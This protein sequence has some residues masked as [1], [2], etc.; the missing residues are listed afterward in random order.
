[1]D[2]K[3]FEEKLEA[4]LRDNPFA[5]ELDTDFEIIEGYDDWEDQGKFQ[6]CSVIVRHKPSG[7]YWSL[8][9]SRYGDHWSGY[10]TEY[11]GLQQVKPEERTVTVYV[12][13]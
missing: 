5:D 1:M 4:E 6:T 2:I 13:V 7:L 3:Q 10:E 8:A 9:F 12:G 11:E